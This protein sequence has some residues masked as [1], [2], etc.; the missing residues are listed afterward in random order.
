MQQ[1]FRI[2]R[3]YSERM[4]GFKTQPDFSDGLLF[5]PTQAV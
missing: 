3:I 1:P 4:I 5:A 2:Y